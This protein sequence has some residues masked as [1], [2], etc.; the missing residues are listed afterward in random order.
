MDAVVLDP[1]GFVVQPAD[2]AGVHRGAQEADIP[3]VRQ[4]SAEACNVVML[5]NSRT[6]RDQ[7]ENAAKTTVGSFKVNNQHVRQLWLRLPPHD[8]QVLIMSE[9]EQRTAA[10]SVRYERARREISLLLEYRTRLIADVVTGKLDVREA[11]AGLPDEP[12]PMDEADNLMN[13][14]E[15]MA[16]DL[17]G[18]PKEA[19]A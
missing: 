11:A 10:L 9:I 5:L 17:D 1:V 8:E 2:A 15:E 14:D 18:I 12:E 3:R 13:S 19:E 7:I 16:D 4:V 6:T